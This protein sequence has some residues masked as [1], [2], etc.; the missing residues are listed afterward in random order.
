MT[1]SI[2]DLN[3]LLLDALAAGKTTVLLVVDDRSR[4]LMSRNLGYMAVGESV[5]KTKVVDSW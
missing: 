5:S 3:G 4:V 1:E 2:G